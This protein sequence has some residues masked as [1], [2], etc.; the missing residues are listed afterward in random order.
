VETELAERIGSVALQAFRAVGG[1]GYGRVDLRLDEANQPFV[2]EVNCNPCLDEGMGIARSADA[3]G[4]PFPQLLQ[5][6]IRAALEPQPYD[7]DVPMLPGR[8]RGAARD[9]DA[10]GTR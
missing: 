3:A 9:G 1:R 10:A 6:I 7:Q 4:I 2:L 8:G 5:L